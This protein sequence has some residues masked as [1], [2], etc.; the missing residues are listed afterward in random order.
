MSDLLARLL[1][2]LPA[3]TAHRAALMGL[4][5]GFGPKASTPADPVLKTALAGLELAHPVG[6]KAE[7]S[8]GRRAP[9]R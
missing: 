3:E 8:A 5:A 2:F 1:T 7:D 6:W 9:C 4:K